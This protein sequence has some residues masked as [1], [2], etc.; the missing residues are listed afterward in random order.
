[1]DFSSMSPLVSIELIRQL[2]SEVGQGLGDHFE[3]LGLRFVNVDRGTTRVEMPYSEHLVGNPATGVLHGGAIT[4]LLDTTCGFAAA[5]VLSDIGVAPTL[6]LRV[7]YLGRGELGKTFFGEGS[8][9]RVTRHIIFTEGVVFQAP[10]KP[11]ARCTATFAP[12]QGEEFAMMSKQL[13]AYLAEV[14]KQ[15]NNAIKSDS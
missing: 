15:K 3:T 13:S 2:C 9:Y 7:D 5:T 8:V 4:T 14:R 6:D 1:M 12:L 10:D 11:I